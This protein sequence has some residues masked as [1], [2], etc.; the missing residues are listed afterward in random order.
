MIAFLLL[1][2]SSVDHQKEAQDALN[3]GDADKA[4]QLA[5]EG[6]KSAGGDKAAAWRL[7]QVRLEALA[8][9]G[10]GASLKGELERLHGAYPQQVTAPLYLKLA[11]QL[12]EGG[13]GATVIDVLDAGKKKWPDDKAFDDA[14][15][16]AQQ[17]ADPAEV[18][19]LK[20]L[21]YIQ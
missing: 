12:R 15:A 20:A 11:S 4:L 5:E 17:N 21:G 3:G 8:K 18:E 19:R 13:G 1:A 9:K 2:C 10:D 7:E 16:E 14:I 6:L